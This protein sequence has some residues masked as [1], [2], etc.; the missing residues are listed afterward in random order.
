MWL[1]H[2]WLHD[3]VKNGCEIVLCTIAKMQAKDLALRRSL[4]FRYIMIDLV[5][6]TVLPYC[7]CIFHQLPAYLHKF[8][9][10]A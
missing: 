9:V 10:V 8:F 4:S 7:V 6:T 1:V 3:E 5:E 2:G